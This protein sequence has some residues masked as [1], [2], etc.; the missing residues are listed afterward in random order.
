[1]GEFFVFILLKAVLLILG[2]ETSS[3]SC[4]DSSFHHFLSLPVGP[5]GPAGQVVKENDETRNRHKKAKKSLHQGSEEWLSQLA[6]NS[7]L[8]CIVVEIVVERHL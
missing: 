2:I 4:A 6:T 7:L 1:M 3:T 5:V 8:T